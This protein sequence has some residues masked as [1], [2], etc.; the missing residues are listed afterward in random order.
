MYFY[1]FQN[2]ICLVKSIYFCMEAFKKIWAYKNG[3][4]GCYKIMTLLR[5]KNIVFLKQ[6]VL[7]LKTKGKDRKKERSRQVVIGIVLV[8]QMINMGYPCAGKALMALSV[9]A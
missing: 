9:F 1:T 7:C 5:E 8:C 6:L 2:I 4:F 3:I